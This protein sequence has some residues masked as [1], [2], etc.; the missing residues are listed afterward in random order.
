MDTPAYQNLFFVSSNLNLVIF[1]LSRLE[2][3][4]DK[5]KLFVGNLP[6][7]ATVDD[8][9]ELFSQYGEV[10]DVFIPLNS[11]GEPRGFAFVT[12]ADG[13]LE[14]IRAGTDGAELLGR[15][16]SVNPPLKPGEKEDR[17]KRDGKVSG[18]RKSIF[19]NH[20]LSRK[21]YML[22][23]YIPTSRLLS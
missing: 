20:P 1:S 22:T 12:C 10:T 16:L 15:T 5:N 11:F 3:I 17:K 14:A 19:G 2:E 8:I 13:N 4:D 7:K 9:K 18:R 23:T 6:F 21:N